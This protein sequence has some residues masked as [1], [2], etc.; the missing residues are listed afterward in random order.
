MNA[1]H[2]PGQR[3][4]KPFNSNPFKPLSP[5]AKCFDAMLKAY[6]DKAPDLIHK[7]G[8]PNRGSSQACGF[9]DGFNGIPP[10]KQPFGSFAYACY[11]A[12]QTKRET[13]A[14]ATGNA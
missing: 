7:D 14:K 1:K 13:I 6:D 4:P 11:R 9:W 12:G 8:R 2:T 5:L 3:I 10:Q